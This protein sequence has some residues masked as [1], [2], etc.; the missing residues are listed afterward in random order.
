MAFF[1]V[2]GTHYMGVPYWIL[3]VGIF[4][5]FLIIG[6]AV[7]PPL[8]TAILTWVFIF[9]PIWAPLV[10]I[11]IWWG[12]WKKYIRAKFIASQTP[13]L[14]EIKV[15]RQI[16]KT[17][18]AMEQVFSSLNFG[19]GETTFISRW[20]DGKVRPWLSFELVSIEGKIHFYVWVWKKHKTYVVSQF[21][22]QYPDLEI[23]EV[24][25]YSAGVHYDPNLVSVWGM[26]YA[27][28]RPDPYPIKTY[29]DFELDQDAK[30]EEQ[31][32]DPLASVF[33][34]L[35]NLGPGEQL[36]VQ[37]IVRQN[38][39]AKIRTTPWSPTKS[40]KD[41]TQ[42]EID[43]IYEKAKPQTKDLVSGELTEGYPLLKPAE[44]S[45][46]KALE[47][48]IDKPGFDAGIRAVYVTRPDAFNGDNIPTHIV[49]LWNSFASGHLNKFSPA[50][51][52]H[53]SIDYPWQEIG[54][55]LARS[56]S[57][58]ILDAYHR[59]GMFHP[60]Y[61][62]PRFV[63]TTEEMATIYHFPTGETKA[64]GID[65]ISSTKGE[66]PANLPV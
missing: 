51:M 25:D 2:G 58:R 37:I 21:Y 29:I 56:Y 13:V 3:T 20:W 49:G 16:F 60:P 33:E 23:Q 63:L 39:G 55:I 9:S 19:P 7:Y 22:A 46:I 50:P 14:L 6:I 15:P 42:E 41:E 43:A 62:R 10:L 54:G 28:A 47:R 17:P 1:Q 32:V 11:A 18:R 48:S 24:E 61:E 12:Q 35:S 27:L 44:V 57:H 52:W 38:K 53:V 40:W 8:L 30:K 64:P 5:L 45:T 26:E 34:R 4:V 66:P 36:W 65:R 31:I 59:R